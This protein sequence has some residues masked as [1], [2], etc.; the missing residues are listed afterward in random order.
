MTELTISPSRKI[1]DISPMLYGVFFEDINYAGDGGLYAELIANRSFEYYDRDGKGDKRN[2]CWEAEG[3]CGFSVQTRFP[4]S[5]EHANYARLDGSAGGGIYNLGF[6]S[7]GFAVREG[8]SFRFSCYARNAAPMS[9]VIRF[10]DAAG[11]PYAE[12]KLSLVRAG[13]GWT[14]YTCTLTASA[15]CACVYAHFLLGRDGTVDLDLLSLFPAD[16]FMQ[17]PGGMRRDIAEMIAALSPKFM[18]FPGGCIVEGRSFENMYGWKE[19][20]GDL[21][22][23]RTNWNRWQMEEYQLE[24]RSSEDYFQS[25]GLGFYEYFQFCEDIGAKPV[26]V[27]NAGMT[28]QWHEGL[29]ADMDKLDKWIQDVLDLIEFACGSPDSEWGGRRA[30][31]GHPEPFN[32]EYIAIGNEQW[33]PAYFERYEAFQK[34][35]SKEHPEIRLITSAGWNSEGKDFDTAYAWM[36]DNRDKAYAVDEHFYKSPGW[37][38]ENVGRY[39]NYDRTLPKVFAGEYA[40]HSSP[41]TAKRVNSWQAALCEAAF[42]TGV[43]RN[44]DHVV[45]TCYAPLLAR[46][47]HNQ[48]QPDLIWFDRTSVYGTPSYYVQKLFSNSTGTALVEAL[49]AEGPLPDTLKTVSSLSGDGGHLYCKLVNLAGQPEEIT[50]RLE[51]AGT[52]YRECACSFLAAE[53][54]AVNSH[55][56]PENVAPQTRK[57]HVSGNTLQLT[58]PKHS[59][60]VLDFY[61]CI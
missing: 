32:L 61:N 29:L 24:G 28:C 57:L 14:K 25:Y 2:M 50:L 43:E 3:G 42:L 18:R 15:T 30:A 60:T 31:M 39:D 40:A 4:L 22:R 38:L 19:T 58:L 47:G 33:G 41:D 13:H 12:K 1:R 37:F 7:E 8:Q 36:R 34:V 27:M 9:L 56:S 48:W 26:P 17:R 45:M 20:V 52:G 11:K 16:T 59:V 53:L 21:S 6:C 44:A 55:Q 5:R 46:S 10:A 35:L 54:D 49:P 23:R 51:A